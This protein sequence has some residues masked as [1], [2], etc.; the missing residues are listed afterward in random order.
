MAMAKTL[1]SQKKKVIKKSSNVSESK[2]T[3]T[4]KGTRS[5]ANSAQYKKNDDDDDDMD[6]DELY[7]SLGVGIINKI[8]SNNI[9]RNLQTG[10]GGGESKEALGSISGGNGSGSG[11]AKTYMVNSTNNYDDDAF[12]SSDAVDD[13]AGKKGGKTANAAEFK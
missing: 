12:E 6:D 13:I 7:G 10:G 3:S 4:I 5:A 9:N 8:K 1:Q 2:K 11:I